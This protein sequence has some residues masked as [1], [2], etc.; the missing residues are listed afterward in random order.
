MT[1]DP[2]HIG[3]NIGDPQS[4]NG[5]VYAGNDPINGVDPLG[6]YVQRVFDASVCE[7]GRGTLI[8]EYIGTFRSVGSDGV[9]TFDTANTG[10]DCDFPDAPLDGNES[11]VANRPGLAP[12][13]NFAQKVDKGLH[14]ALEK[15]IAH[16]GPCDALWGSLGLDAADVYRMMLATMFEDAAV[17][18]RIID[19]VVNPAFARAQQVSGWTVQQLFRN[20]GFPNGPPNQAMVA[21]SPPGGTVFFNGA[22][23][24]WKA[25]VHETLHQ[26]IGAFDDDDIMMAWGAPRDRRTGRFPASEWI[27]KRIGQRC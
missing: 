22:F 19:N 23:L 6:L 16:K 8:A 27:S 17:S 24:N 1:P 18:N 26:F 2:G 10:Y 7:L 14:T 9:V 4:W 25:M 5:Y 12:A 11:Q 15:I 20:G 3:A 13:R 21:W